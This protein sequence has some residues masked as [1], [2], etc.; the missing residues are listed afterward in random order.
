MCWYRSVTQPSETASGKRWLA[1]FRSADTE[2]ATALLDNLCFV[3]LETL[4]SGL[5]EGLEDLRSQEKIGV[6]A[7]L[8]AER[9][10]GDLLK[11]SGVDRGSA[12]AY[13]DFHPGGRISSTPGSEGMIGMVL[14]D[15]GV[16]GSSGAENPW[17]APGSPLEAL[18]DRRCRTIVVVTDYCGSGDQVG[19]LADAIARNP[20]IRSWLSLKV[21]EIHVLAFAAS[22]LA[23]RNL[24]RRPSVSATH[25]IE[26]AP[27]LDTAPW[28]RAMKKKVVDLCRQENRVKGR[29][30]GYRDSR[31]LLATARRAPNNLPA[32]FW[33]ES[34]DWAPLFPGRTVSPEVARD[35]SGHTPKEELPTLAAR[36]G[37]SRLSR[38]TRHEYMRVESRELLR[39]LLLIQRA[40]RSTAELSAQLGTPMARTKSLLTTLRKLGLVDGEHRI[41]PA[42]RAEIRAQKR[43][44]RRTD[45]G[46]VGSRDTYYPHGLR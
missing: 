38:S 1:N 34:H 25:T 8:V 5:I 21:I 24:G 42:G 13:T 39:V 17:M 29:A 28:S 41:T 19:T 10:L 12:V 3:D 32:L 18:R 31:G 30:L 9:N 45:A 40:T 26:A 33:Q 6:P 23:L 16:A 11:E 14:R 46:L 7:L 22:P 44:I 4:R 37:Q 27:S 35:L 15:F 36:V 43:A 20:T 2:P